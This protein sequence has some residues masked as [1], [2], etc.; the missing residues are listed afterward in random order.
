MPPRRSNEVLKALARDPVAGWIQT[1]LVKATP[2]GVAAGVNPPYMAAFL[3]HHELPTSYEAMKNFNGDR[4]WARTKVYLEAGVF[5]DSNLHPRGIEALAKVFNHGFQA[6]LEAQDLLISFLESRP[7]EDYQAC[8]RE[9]MRHYQLCRSFRCPR[10]EMSDPPSHL[11]LFKFEEVPKVWSV[12]EGVERVLINANAVLRAWPELMSPNWDATNA[13]HDA[14][15]HWVTCGVEVDELHAQM[16][17][18]GGEGSLY[19]KNV[20]SRFIY[21]LRCHSIKMLYQKNPVI[22]S[23]KLL[24]MTGYVKAIV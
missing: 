23:D 19:K 16:E 3:K 10:A 14:D 5:D 7:E 22:S 17:N 13:S 21:E 4:L 6:P 12:V 18:E 15:S 8:A 11:D 9:M 2:A 1:P 20:T 24:E